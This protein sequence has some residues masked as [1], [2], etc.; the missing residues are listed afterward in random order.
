[1]VGSL[2]LLNLAGGECVEDIEQLEADE[3]LCEVVRRVELHGLPRRERRSEERRLRRGRERT[4]ASPSSI[5]RYLER[6]D[7][8]SH[9]EQRVAH[10]AYIPPRTAGLSGLERVNADLLA[11]AQRISPER[12]AT[13]DMDATLV[14]THKRTALCCYKGYR[15]YQPLNTYWA[16]QGL[17]VH[18]EFRDGNVPA[19][20]EQRRVLTEA[21]ACLP[22]GVDKVFLRSDTAGYQADLL[23]Y[24]AEG[25]DPRFGVIEFAIGADVTTEFKKA[26]GQTPESAWTPLTRLIA[27]EWKATGQ[28]WAEIVYV[29]GWAH[30]KNGPTYR[31]L[32]IRELLPQ[33]ELPGLASQATLPFPTLSFGTRGTY[34]LHGIV[35]NRSRPA[36]ELIR[37]YRERCGKS[38]EA[39]AVMKS[40]L[41]G[42]R[43]PSWKFG[44]NAAWWQIMLLALNLN[45]IMRRHVLG[46]AWLHRR[47][48]AIRFAFIRLAGWVR[49]HAGAL[50]IRLSH[51]HPS[52]RWLLR[53]RG[54]I[55]CLAE[56]GPP[57]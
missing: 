3:G 8:P 23:R 4:F 30:S 17:V 51:G 40:D 5:F 6:F 19:G 41:A 9:E 44:A 25:R 16:E 39:H 56:L 29:P 46:G 27:G 52:I 43:M 28:E 12:V 49:R 57:G 13:L 15:A 7:E 14:E 1:M 53:A 38:E 2:V 11:F 22:Q 18:S 36:P 48:K 42:G 31:F 21:L 37:W 20:H 54:R 50:D 45:A 35:T 32:A 10:T 34:K 33:L 47:M 55:R 24:C 26:V